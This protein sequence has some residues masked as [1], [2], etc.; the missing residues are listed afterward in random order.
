MRSS[1][2]VLTSSPHFYRCQSETAKSPVAPERETAVG[3][4]ADYMIGSIFNSSGS[5]SFSKASSKMEIILA[6]TEHVFHF[7]PVFA[8]INFNKWRYFVIKAFLF[9]AAI[10]PVFLCTARRWLADWS[11]TSNP[12]SVFINRPGM[13]QVVGDR[14]NLREQ[15]ALYRHSPPGTKPVS[16]AFR[17][18]FVQLHSKHRNRKKGM[19]KT[20]LLDIFQVLSQFR[21]ILP[22]ISLEAN[23]KLTQ[24]QIYKQ[25]D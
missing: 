5:C 25:I 11:V 9:H 12:G 17:L 22:T 13:Q 7:T 20:W 16:F 4:N 3:F 1:T 8:G 6:H 2:S 19:W 21:N 14:K 24:N 18:S 23:S 15:S 10:S